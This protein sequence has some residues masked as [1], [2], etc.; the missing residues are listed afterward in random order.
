TTSGFFVADTLEDNGLEILF[1]LSNPGVLSVEN[2]SLTLDEADLLLSPEFSNALG[3][4][5]FT[6][7]DVGN[8]RTDALLN[9]FGVLTDV[10]DDL[11]N[12]VRE[13]I[14]QVINEVSEEA[15]AF[16]TGF[17]DDVTAD[18]VIDVATDFLSDLTGDIEQFVSSLGISSTQS[19]EL[20]SIAENPESA[21]TTLAESVFSIF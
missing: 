17:L 6:G 13:D 16:A 21:L 3:L 1:D 19:S 14:G 4:P 10:I 20:A 8:A 12:N 9:E 7:A 15:L 18:G 2:D 11:L 5:D